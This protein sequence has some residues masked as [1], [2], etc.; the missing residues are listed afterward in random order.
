MPENHHLPTRLVACPPKKPAVSYQNDMYQAGNWDYVR[1]VVAEVK[2]HKGK[3]FPRVGFIV[4]NLPWRRKRV[5][6]F[7]NQRSTAEK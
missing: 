1:R 3:L 2:W 7:Y 5:V 6:R 4:T